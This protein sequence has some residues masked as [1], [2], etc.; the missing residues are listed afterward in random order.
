M[1][2]A[3][4]VRSAVVAM[5]IMFLGSSVGLAH[6]YGRTDSRLTS[7]AYGA[8]YN[9][10]STIPITVQIVFD[11]TGLSY[12]VSAEQPFC[13]RYEVDLHMEYH[14][15]WSWSWPPWPHWQPA[16]LSSQQYASST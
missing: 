6:A 3:I 13:L 14:K 12:P 5:V 9:Y 10:G 7:P 1:D 8:S 11:T 16:S 4:H 15:G 2:R